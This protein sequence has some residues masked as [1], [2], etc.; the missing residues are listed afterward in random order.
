MVQAPLNSCCMCA[1]L[2]TLAGAG[3]SGVG[4]DWAGGEAASE[5]SLCHS[6]CLCPPGRDRKQGAEGVCKRDTQAPAWATV[7]LNLS[8][9]GAL[10]S[11]L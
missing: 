8:R 6:G 3:S 5:P 2:G 11:K 9:A 10:L 4:L 1:S 7:L